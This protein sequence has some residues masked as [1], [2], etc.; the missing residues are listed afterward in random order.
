MSDSAEQH[1]ALMR[2]TGAQPYAPPLETEPPEPPASVQPTPVGQVPN[3][4]AGIEIE[5]AGL[6][7]EQGLQ[8]P[9][10]M[11]SFPD[12]SKV[13]VVPSVLPVGAV[14]GM[15]ATPLLP[16]ATAVARSFGEAMASIGDFLECAS[17]VLD[18]LDL[19]EDDDGRAIWLTAGE[20]ELDQWLG[21]LVAARDAMRDRLTPGEES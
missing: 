21:R 20:V 13:E 9:Q 17:E 10:L 19:I 1:T 11:Q 14:T 18:Q 7:F 2:A 6:A 4:L 15:F 3:D 5:A 8:G 12:G 16:A